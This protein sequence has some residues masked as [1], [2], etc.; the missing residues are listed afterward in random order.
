MILAMTGHREIKDLDS[1]DS[2]L[3]STMDE[4]QPQAWVQGMADGADLRSALIAINLKVPVISAI[5]WQTHYKTTE[6]IETYRFVLQHSEECFVVTEEEEY[7]GPWLFFRRNE[8]MIDEC[9]KV[10]AWWDGR[11]SGGTFGAIKYANKTNKP[12]RNLYHE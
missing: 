9:D 5:P 6:D 3:I 7:V 8:W 12:V 4:A 2:R 10:V 1:F 11:Q